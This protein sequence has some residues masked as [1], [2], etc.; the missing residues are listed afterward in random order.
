MF[1]SPF[2]Y[3]EI[4]WCRRWFLRKLIKVFHNLCL[5]SFYLCVLWWHMAWKFNVLKLKF[6][7]MNPNDVNKSRNKT[8]RNSYFQN[9]SGSS[10]II[11]WVVSSN[12]FLDLFKILFKFF[13]LS[14][15]DESPCYKDPWHLSKCIEALPFPWPAYCCTCVRGNIWIGNAFWKNRKNGPSWKIRKNGPSWKNR[16]NGPFYRQFYRK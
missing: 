8:F 11:G 10:E 1:F 12:T 4:L 6:Y 2:L 5:Y 16:E 9:G 14:I 15:W 7:L 13:I 3:T